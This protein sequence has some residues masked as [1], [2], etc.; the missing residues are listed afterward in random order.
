[1]INKIFL[2]YLLLASTLLLQGCDSAK[3]ALGGGKIKSS[4]EFLV[5]KKDP[6]VLPPNFNELP[7]PLEKNSNIEEKN[8]E[9]EKIINIQEKQDNSKSNSGNNTLEQS[10]L[11]KIK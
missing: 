9:I 4:D 10:I 7:S 5:E 8:M 2:F 11:K 6:L 3:K 1:M